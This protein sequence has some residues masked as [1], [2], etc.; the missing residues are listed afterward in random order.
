[1]RRLILVVLC[2]LFVIPIAAEEETIVIQPYEQGILFDQLTGEVTVLEPG[3]HTYDS[4][5]FEIT[6]YNVGQHEYTMVDTINPNL[7]GDAI[8]A[9]TLDG[10]EV[11]VDLT[12]L[13]SIE[14]VELIHI[15]WQRRYEDG[16]VRSATRAFTRDVIAGYT[17]EDLYGEMRGEAEAMLQ[18]MLEE[19]FEE[20]GLRVT[21]VL[22]RNVAFSEE[23]TN[24]VEQ[25][26]LAQ[27]RLEQAQIEAEIAL[28]EARG[29]A[30]I[31]M[32]ESYL[33]LE[34]QPEVEALLN[35]EQAYRVIETDDVV[36]VIIS[37]SRL[38]EL[39]LSEIDL[40]TE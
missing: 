13:Y 29:Q 2:F 10:Q 20:E 32:L 16:F 28:I 7:P 23:Y 33:E 4:T 19:R 31:A 12:I 21:D 15:N 8:N 34:F 38:P 18:T 26:V 36:I 35:G 14:D 6:V 30:E 24:A 22:V 39:N 5:L 17:A 25:H 9:R 27:Q 1:M 11:H 37:K 3:T 40:D